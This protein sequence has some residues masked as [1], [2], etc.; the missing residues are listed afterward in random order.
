MNLEKQQNLNEEPA[1]FREVHGQSPMDLEEPYE[2]D[3]PQAL[4]STER[5]EQVSDKELLTW[6]FEHVGIS[7]NPYGLARAMLRSETKLGNILQNPHIL[8][9][10]GGT[11]EEVQEL[12]QAV[13]ALQQVVERT[14]FAAL[15]GIDAQEHPD[16]LAAYLRASIGYRWEERFCLL[17]CDDRGVVLKNIVQHVGSIDHTPVY[18]REVVRETLRHGATGVI[19][20]HNH[21]SNVPTLS[22]ADVDMTTV[23]SNTLNNVHL[24][25]LDHMVVSRTGHARYREAY[26]LPPSEVAPDIPAVPG[27]SV[28][29]GMTDVATSV[30]GEPKLTLETREFVGYSPRPLSV[31][32][33]TALVDMLGPVLT[34]ETGS[35]ILDDEALLTWLLNQYFS[36]SKGVSGL[37]RPLLASAGSLGA[38]L[39]NPECMNK[40]TYD[41]H[42]EAMCTVLEEVKKFFVVLRELA[43][44][45]KRPQEFTPVRLE[46]WDKLASY[47]RQ[48]SI[49][50]MAANQALKGRGAQ[51][52]LYLDRSNNLTS[53]ELLEIAEN[54]RPEQFVR[55]ITARCLDLHASAVVLVDDDR[56]TGTEREYQAPR[57]E[58]VRLTQSL[59][60][61]LNSVGVV[62]H[63]RLAVT[64]TRYR[65]YRQ[66]DLL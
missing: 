8:D 33:E 29:S 46:N 34:E 10:Y 28:Q 11:H 42:D 32:A 6:L 3:V 62:L 23:V 47:V 7:Q 56:P 50:H 53:D 58:D 64:F 39:C 40:L 51:R 17:L 20:A 61:A 16:E 21:P 66:S 30:L 38:L 52:I 22:K 26:P 31:E 49:R 65:S 5:A 4:T 9:R 27:Q 41:E 12:K 59:K 13:N 60:K 37:A 44:R 45:V 19:M 24:K 15:E 18:P 48:T 57:N 2:I 14:V 63:D 25:M 54:A 36:K 1:L 55:Q 43:E 35:R